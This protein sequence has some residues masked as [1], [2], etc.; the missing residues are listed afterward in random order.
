[1][2]QYFL[3]PVLH[4][5][6]SLVAQMLKNLPAMQQTWVWSLGLKDTLEEEMATHSSILAWRIPWAEEPHSP[7]G[8]KE[9]DTTE[10]LTPM[11]SFPQHEITPDCNPLRLWPS[12]PPTSIFC[13]ST[14]GRGGRGHKDL[15]YNSLAS[16]KVSRSSSLSVKWMNEWMNQW[17][18]KWVSGRINQ[19]V[20][21]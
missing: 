17:M 14:I 5:E 10:R 1:M 2:P 15:T 9:L 19:R 13:L 20:S 3:T 16:S 18:N 6:S 21:V 11:H 7:W 4:F 12:L 8:C